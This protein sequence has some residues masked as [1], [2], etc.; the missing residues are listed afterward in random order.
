MKKFCLLLS[1]NC[2]LFFLI[3]VFSSINSA[4]CCTF[5]NVSLLCDSLFRSRKSIM[6]I[7]FGVRLYIIFFNCI[8]MSEIIN[9]HFILNIIYLFILPVFFIM[10]LCLYR[11][12]YSI[13]PRRSN[14]FKYV[15]VV[16]PNSR[17]RNSKNYIFFYHYYNGNVIVVLL[18]TYISHSAFRFMRYISGF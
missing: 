10:F 3:F 15:A 14:T 6:L 7:Y 16:I 1:I 17:I 11:S 8:I 9:L 18:Y 13:V 5:S 4:W 2:Y 12:L